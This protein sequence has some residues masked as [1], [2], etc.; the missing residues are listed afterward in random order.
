MINKSAKNPR[1][2]AMEVLMLTLEEGK[3][4]HLALRGK[5]EEYMLSDKQD[6]AFITRITEGTIER[7]ITIDYIIN[8]FSK[9]K[10]K[11]LKPII[12]EILRFSVYQIIYMEG[13]PDSAACNE[14]VKIVKKRGLSNLSGFVNGVLR[15]ISR[16]KDLIKY[17][18]IKSDFVAYYSILYSIPKWIIKSFINDYGKETA[19]SMVENM[20]EPDNDRL[21]VRINISK[22]DKSEV[23]SKLNE[24]NIEVLES[25]LADN[26]LMLKGYDNVY[27]INAFKEGL[28]QVQDISSMLVG[29]I[30][31]VKENDK[32]IDM[33]AAPG[34]KSIHI[35]D[36]LN[37][38]GIIHSRD[39]SEKKVK[40]IKENVERCNFKN[41]SVE[42][43]DGTEF[44]ESD[45]ESA[46]IVIA[47]VPC[48]GMGILRKKTDIKYNIDEKISKELAILSQKILK[49]SIK[50]LKKGGILIFSTCTMNSIENDNNRKWLIEEMKMKPV[51]F[52]NSLSDDILNIGNNRKMAEEGYLQLFMTSEY[53]GFYISKF[54][55]VQ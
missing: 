2:V 46:D 40:L 24:Q 5:L 26:A 48:T 9:V 35:A 32:C 11:K 49:N 39:I 43:K 34:G 44:N 18:D 54:I 14:A 29:Q 21:S 47:D 33:C 10:V 13:V 37:G 12:R 52:T 53:D 42:I 55:K 19:I 41:I 31:G 51:N 1:E 27:D 50:Y 36:I 4:S 30:C 23:V 17:P 28:I 15:N 3:L 16:N 22:A 38:T 45:E 7:K 6:K 8:Q 20:Y 25:K